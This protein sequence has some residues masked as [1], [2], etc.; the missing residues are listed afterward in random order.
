MFEDH[1]EAYEVD[2]EQESNPE[3][4]YALE[5]LNQ[6]KAPMDLKGFSPRAI[7]LAKSLEDT[8]G[9]EGI[10]QII[11]HDMETY[12]TTDGIK[13][14]FERKITDNKEFIRAIG[15]IGRLVEI[16]EDPEIQETLLADEQL[17]KGIG[18]IF[19]KLTTAQKSIIE[20]IERGTGDQFFYKA[21][22]LSYHTAGILRALL[23]KKENPGKE[24]QKIKSFKAS[25]DATDNPNKKLF[26]SII[27]YFK[28]HQSKPIENIPP[29]LKI[30]IVISNGIKAE[31]AGQL[32]GIASL[33]GNA[34]S[35]KIRG[36]GNES[37]IVSSDEEAAREIKNNTI[38]LAIVGSDIRNN[39]YLRDHLAEHAVPFIPVMID[40]G[41]PIA[42]EIQKMIAG[43]IR[44]IQDSISSRAQSLR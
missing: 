15:S 5:K 27:D 16:I 8:M 20:F 36:R 18:A 39:G 43:R 40:V 4:Q 10:P 3:I 19:E 1:K 44:K 32:S 35:Q 33:D 38:D 17:M 11:N 42:Q 12:V 30:L 2:W 24:L 13:N 25:A 21:A 9:V 29:K 14:I 26:K 22:L 7:S 23:Q 28:L 41:N 6:I 37:I 31:L 34:E